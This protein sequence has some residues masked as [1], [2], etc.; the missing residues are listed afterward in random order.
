MT[1]K[2]ALFKKS[3][4]INFDMYKMSYK[5]LSSIHFLHNKIANIYYSLYLESLKDDFTLHESWNTVALKLTYK[6]GNPSDIK[7]IAQ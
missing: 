6:G 3:T 4:C 5:F 2:R 1:F 7:G